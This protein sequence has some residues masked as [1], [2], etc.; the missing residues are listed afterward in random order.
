MYV[1]L[2]YD[3]SISDSLLIFDS[4]LGCIIVQ[5]YNYFTRNRDSLSLKAFVRDPFPNPMQQ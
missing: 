5:G 1:D 4:L 3:S 2:L